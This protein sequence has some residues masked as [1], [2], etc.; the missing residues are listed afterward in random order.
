MKGLL[1]F[2]NLGHE[3]SKDGEVQNIERVI[4]RGEALLGS[5]SNHTK[6]R[7]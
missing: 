1:D 7:K 3:K 6:S 5:A 2:V 4:G